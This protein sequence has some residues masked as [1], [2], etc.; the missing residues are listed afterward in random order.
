MQLPNK[1]AR[2]YLL[3][4]TNQCAQCGVTIF[5]SSWSE[6]VDDHR[7]RDLWECHIC[8]YTFETEVVFPVADAA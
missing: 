6:R 2:N 7:V 8:G 5:C 1:D 3:R 4:K